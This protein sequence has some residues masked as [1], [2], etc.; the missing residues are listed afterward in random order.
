MS[1]FLAALQHH[2]RRLVASV[3]RGLITV[4]QTFIGMGLYSPSYER[5]DYLDTAERARESLVEQE[6]E[7]DVFEPFTIAD[8]VPYVLGVDIK[9]GDKYCL[10]C[11]E[12]LTNVT[13]HACPVLA[14]QAPAAS[15]VADAVPAIPPAGTTDPAAGV[16]PP[17]PAAGSPT[18]NSYT[19]AETLTAAAN[20]LDDIRRGFDYT[21]LTPER[22]DLRG[23][24]THLRDRAAAFD[25]EL[26]TPK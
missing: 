23:F 9:V 11:G 2:T 4:D 19:T 8:G 26:R 17:A 24:I 5:G 16:L 15:V 1:L 18:F 25:P 3:E 6:A 13:Y 7:E 21:W 12:N 14:S 22:Y 20:I 10:L